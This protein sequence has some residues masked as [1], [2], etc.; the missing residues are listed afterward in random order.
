MTR[1]VEVADYLRTDAALV[2]LVPGGIY[3]DEKLPADGS[4]LTN[5]KLMTKVWANGIFN[6]TIVVRERAP[7]PTGDLQSIA[8][9]RTSTSQAVEIRAYGLTMAAVIDARK[10]VYALMMGHRLSAAFS[11]TWVSAL[12]VMQ[13]PELPPGIR[14]GMEAYRI[15]FIRRAI[16]V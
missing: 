13:A 14:V 9:Q 2:V 3:P 8:S 12:P 11:A 15:V 7:V 6:T 16:T 10:R 4:G 5:A 1:E